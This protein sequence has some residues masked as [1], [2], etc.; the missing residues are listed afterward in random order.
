[1]SVS[2]ELHPHAMKMT[3][4][5]L[6]ERFSSLED[7]TLS[8]DQFQ[9]LITS[10]NQRRNQRL[11]H[12]QPTSEDVTLLLH[13]LAE[14]ED[15][16]ITLSEFEAWVNKGLDLSVHQLISFGKK[17]N[18]QQ[19]LVNFLQSLALDINNVVKR[20]ISSMQRYSF[21]GS[22]NTPELAPTPTLTLTSISIPT[23]TSTPYVLMLD[24]CA[25]AE[26]LS[27]VSRDVDDIPALRLDTVSH[28]ETSSFFAAFVYTSSTSI[29]MDDVMS[30]YCRS[31]VD[32][33]LSVVM[34]GEQ[35]TN[36]CK[37]WKLLRRKA[38]RLVD[39]ELDQLEAEE[40]NEE[41]MNTLQRR[42]EQAKENT[43]ERNSH[44]NI[45]EMVATAPPAPPAPTAPPAP[46]LEIVPRHLQLELMEPDREEYA[47]EQDRIKQD[48][49][50][51]VVEERTRMRPQPS[52]KR[53]A[54]SFLTREHSMT[55]TNEQTNTQTKT[56]TKNKRLKI[57]RSRFQHQQLSSIASTAS[58]TAVGLYDGLSYAFVHLRQPSPPTAISVDDILA[59]SKPT[60]ITFDFSL[61][62]LI[63]VEG[64][65]CT[66]QKK[67]KYSTAKVLLLEKLSDIRENKTTNEEVKI[68]VKVKEIKKKKEVLLPLPPP[69][70]SLS[71]S[72]SVPL[73]PKKRCRQS[74]AAAGGSEENNNNFTCKSKSTNE[75]ENEDEDKGTN[76]NDILV[77]NAKRARI[78]TETISEITTQECTTSLLMKCDAGLVE[79]EEIKIEQQENNQLSLF[80]P[81]ATQNTNAFG[82]GTTL[83]IHSSNNDNST[84]SNQ[85]LVNELDVCKRQSICTDARCGR[86]N[87]IKN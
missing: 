46:P 42:Q 18:F 59:F 69:S 53:K 68:K 75:N 37:C 84:R 16:N 87:A 54:T 63:A 45:I 1:M 3:I 25:F 38:Y 35:S 41:R 4:A 81:L 61:E 80:S 6:F 24:A 65:V 82:F 14:N 20:V 2:D 43:T 60:Q 57:D 83:G 79:S 50:Q 78:T 85:E 28:I 15:G 36:C 11:T 5:V 55:T 22:D 31:I 72:M 62:R 47:T 12:Q 44:G 13:A 86:C 8:V 33:S 52:P 9:N 29:N 19:C 49:M 32:E 51:N 58:S 27:S 26:M 39:A 21:H 48:M 66:Q 23:P 70:V 17:S 74:A 7:G 64:V 34:G 40:A 67:Q 76:K 71:G 10:C 56:Q 30:F 77:V 73:S